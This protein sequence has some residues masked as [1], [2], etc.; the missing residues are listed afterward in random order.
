MTKPLEGIKVV[1]L[2]NYVAAPVVGRMCADMGAEVIKIEGRGGDAWRFTAAG[3][4]ITEQDE[5]PMFDTFNA[6]KKSI[7]LNLK[8]PEGKEVFFRLLHRLYRLL[9]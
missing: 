5:N 3:L 7:S 9:R 4:T 6:G 8:A 1:E 2:A